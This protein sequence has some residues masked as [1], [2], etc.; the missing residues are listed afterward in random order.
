MTILKE[1]ALSWP[2]GSK[3]Q[4]R[5]F[6]LQTRC[7]TA[8]YE[9]LFPSFKTERCWKVLLECVEHVTKK[10]YR[11]LLGVYTLEVTADVGSFFSLSDAEK[12]EW[13]WG[14]LC[15]GIYGL[16]EQ[17]TWQREPFSETR[18]RVPARGNSPRSDARHR[19]RRR[20]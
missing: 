16:L 19:V 14:T 6:S 10:Q 8:L 3:E 5:A 15:A 20:Q 11:D 7:V 13:T 4:R 18:Q 12:K 17:T 9:R 1:F 2:T